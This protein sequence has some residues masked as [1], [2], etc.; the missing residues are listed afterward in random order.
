GHMWV[1]DW[2][3]IIVQH[4][5]TPAGFRTGKGAA[6]ESEHRDKKHG[7]IYRIVYT[8]AKPSKNPDLSTPAGMVTGL[9]HDNMRWRRQ[10]RRLL[11]ERGKKDALPELLKLIEDRSVDEIALNVGAIHALWTL[12]GLK[13]I[14]ERVNVALKHPSAGVRRN[15]ALVASDTKAIIPL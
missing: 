12:H 8:G 2:Y 13:A 14:D 4:N 1:L 3:N 9:K 6:Y 15:A 5:P 11:V 10:A 7:R